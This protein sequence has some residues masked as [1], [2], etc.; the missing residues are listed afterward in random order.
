MKASG[1]TLFRGGAFKPRTS[2]YDFQG[3]GPAGL[4]MLQAARAATGLPILDI[5]EKLA[6][7]RVDRGIGKH[8]NKSTTIYRSTFNIFHYL[9]LSSI[10]YYQKKNRRVISILSASGPTK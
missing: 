2:P 6:L 7:A 4:E 9:A 1:A 3:L 10:L 5:L 8:I